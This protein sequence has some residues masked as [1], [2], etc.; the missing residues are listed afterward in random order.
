MRP[1]FN[2]YRDAVSSG[3]VKL[4]EDAAAGYVKEEAFAVPEVREY[5][6]GET[7]RLHEQVRAILEK[8]TPEQID[9]RVTDDVVIDRLDI[10]ST[11]TDAI[12]HAVAQ[13]EFGTE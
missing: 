10:S 8:S 2:A 5:L 13:V 9:S 7:E 11:I 12:V 4:E 3:E 6:L 1:Y